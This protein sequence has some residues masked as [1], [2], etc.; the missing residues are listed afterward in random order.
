[1]MQPRSLLILSSVIA[2]ACGGTVD[3]PP[4]D[5][6]PTNE[7][8]S[9]SDADAAP[10]AAADGSCLVCTA[11]ASLYNVC[12]HQTYDACTSCAVCGDYTCGTCDDAAAPVDAAAE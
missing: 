8:A 7:A 12:T 9:A 10:D 2:L 6:A 4:D 1:M 11:A 5:A 3:N